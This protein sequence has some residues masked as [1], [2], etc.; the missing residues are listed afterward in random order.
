MKIQKVQS[1][2]PSFG[3]KVVMDPVA[4]RQIAL[5]GAGKK[6]K[7]HIKILENNGVND[8]MYLSY[9]PCF[10]IRATVMEKRGNDYFLNQAYKWANL[11][12]R[13]DNGKNKYV[14][15]INLYKEAKA[16]EIKVIIDKPNFIS[17]LPYIGK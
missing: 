15:L 14:N 9:A 17:F 1:Y 11:K 2:H 7:K 16:N 8:T 10:T 5:S 6:I 3:T 13:Q 12:E 4:A